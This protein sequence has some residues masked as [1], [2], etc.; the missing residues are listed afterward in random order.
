MLLAA[1]FQLKPRDVVYVA[2]YNVTRWARIMNQITPTINS[3][4]QVYNAVQT[5]K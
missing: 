4:W 2:S 5:S 1:S 3:M